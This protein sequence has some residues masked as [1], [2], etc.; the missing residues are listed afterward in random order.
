MH[1]LQKHHIEI[2]VAFKYHRTFRRPGDIPSNHEAM[3]SR[4]WMPTASSPI[5]QKLEQIFICGGDKI[6]VSQGA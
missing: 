4:H 6:A 5:C 3:R 1:T 2:G